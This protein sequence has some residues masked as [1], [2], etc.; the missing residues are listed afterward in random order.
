LLTAI[1]HAFDV[2]AN[3]TGAEALPTRVTAREGV[4]PSFTAED[5]RYPEP[6]YVGLREPF[7]RFSYRD[8]SYLDAQATISLDRRTL[9]LSA[10]NYHPTAAIDA[11]VDL[12]PTRARGS[13][14][15]VELN[16]ADTH[17]PNT[18]ERP[19]VTG[20]IT[21]TVAEPVER[22]TFPA[23]SATVLQFHLEDS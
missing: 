14:A 1:Y 10:I 23:H 2:Y 5:W 18:F 11:A 21:H 13:V 3:H 16:G 22:Y 17:T 4:V 9:F 15:V 20:V 12:G 6:R 7:L 19:N 8:V